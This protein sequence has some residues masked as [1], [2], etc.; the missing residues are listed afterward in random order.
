M[1]LVMSK[2]TVPRCIYHLYYMSL[3]VRKP[4]FRVSDQVPHKPVCTATEDDYMLEISDLGR[5]GI[6]LSV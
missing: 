5:R 6:V 4:V 1:S 2:P 3:I